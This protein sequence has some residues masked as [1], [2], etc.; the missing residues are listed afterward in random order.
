MA[1]VIAGFPDCHRATIT[2]RL[3]WP[4]VRGALADDA[5]LSQLYQTLQKWGVGR[6]A[7]RLVPLAEFRQALRSRVAEIAE[8]EAL[9]IDDP[10]LD[11]AD[12]AESLW[13]LIEQLGVVTNVALIVAGSKTLHHLLPDL[14]P[15]MDRA[16][17]GA[18]FRWSAAG[19][20]S[21]LRVTFTRTF[22]GFAEIA[23]ATEPSRY[24]GQGWQTS[25]TKV[26]DNAIIG[27][28]KT[29]GIPSA[30]AT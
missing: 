24:T 14:V 23:R 10:A 3:R 5:L 29:H 18:F 26:L 11:A 30:N 17:T 28:C 20:Q 27:Y 9:S 25:R 1:D 12:T 4:D 19:P 13:S 16:W 6:R 7:S 8:F 21:A 15:P 2:G 22:T